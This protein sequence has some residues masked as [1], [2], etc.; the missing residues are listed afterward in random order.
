VFLESLSGADFAHT[1][2]IPLADMRRRVTPAVL[3]AA[4]GMAGLGRGGLR[5]C[6]QFLITS[7]EGADSIVLSDE[8]LLGSL[9]CFSRKNGLY[10]GADENLKVITS[11]FEKDID[12]VIYLSIRSYASWLESVY[13]Q[14][15]KKGK[16]LV[17]FEEFIELAHVES[18]SWYALVRRLSAA[19][20]AAKIMLWRY[21]A[22]FDNN[23]KI[24]DGI[25]RSLGHGRLAPVDFSGNP[26]LS[27][28]AYEILMAA[29]SAGIRGRDARP[30]VKFVRS[31]FLASNVYSK[32]KL[33]G[34]TDSQRLSERYEKDLS[35]LLG[36]GNVALI[37]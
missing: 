14:F 31:H 5:D 9:Y 23:Q 33:F 21:E 29:R 17:A 3:R 24:L 30:L 13:L 22:F 12:I 26:S 25:S 35:L 4:K 18:M 2:Y 10:P 34:A 11:L 6:R 27:A 1:V 16:R 8:N 7:L 28:V 20:P 36:L 32:P 19:A 37:G 15:L